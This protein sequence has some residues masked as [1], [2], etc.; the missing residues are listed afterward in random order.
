[1]SIT[2]VNLQDNRDVFRIFITLLRFSFDSPSYKMYESIKWPVLL[3]KR[4][5]WN[6]KCF[7]LH[8]EYFL[9]WIQTKCFTNEQA[10]PYM[11]YLTKRPDWDTQQT[12]RDGYLGTFPVAKQSARPHRCVGAANLHLNV[13]SA[14][15][16]H[17]TQWPNVLVWWG[18]PLLAVRKFAGSNLSSMA[19]IHTVNICDSLQSSSA[20]WYVV[21][22]QG[23]PTTSTLVEK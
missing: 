14:T 8:V 19:I 15:A 7:V 23:N 6:W 16:Q 10:E 17:R 13:T 21:D 9:H 4:R 18:E 2:V 12:V 5:V 11:Q 20:K 1:M 22:V 3:W